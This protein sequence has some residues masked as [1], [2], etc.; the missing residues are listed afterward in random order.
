[1]GFEDNHNPELKNKFIV[2][3]SN[4]GFN[5]G[6]IIQS[7]FDFI[8]KNIPFDLRN[9]CLLLGFYFNKQTLEV[10]PIIYN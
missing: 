4:K 10:F 5:I 1:M 7:M 9:D 6:D 8:I 2:C 3:E